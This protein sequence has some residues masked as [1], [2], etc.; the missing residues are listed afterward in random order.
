[1]ELSESL[2]RSST[3][4]SRTWK[5]STRRDSSSYTIEGFQE[6]KFC[7]RRCRGPES[8]R[9][10]TALQA[11]TLPLC[12]PGLHR[13]RGL[14]N[15]KFFPEIQQRLWDKTLSQFL[16]MIA[17]ARRPMC[18]FR[19]S[20]LAELPKVFFIYRLYFRCTTFSLQGDI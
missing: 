20:I 8:N 12:H 6:L 7:N 13:M 18:F 17:W 16:S 1:M 5:G 11:I 4:N 2:E 10:K 15:I 9:L 3:Q 19:A 14:S